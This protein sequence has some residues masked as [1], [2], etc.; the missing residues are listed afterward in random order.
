M[1]NTTSIIFGIAL[2]VTG[3]AMGQNAGI[4]TTTPNADSDLELGSS[5]KGLLLNRVAL[6]GTANAA[7]L[8]AHVAGMT[9][10]NTATAGD[11]TPGYYYNDGTVWVRVAD[12]STVTG[13]HDWYTEGGTSA[14]T[15]ITD[16]IFTEGSLRFGA[17]TNTMTGTNSI[18][19]G[20]STTVSGD[21]SG[22]IG[23][24]NNVS[25]DN[26]FSLGSGNIVGGNHALSAGSGNTVNGDR[27]ISWG[28]DNM[29]TGARSASGGND[30]T[31]SG[32]AS[33]ATGSTNTV[34]DFNSMAVG[35]GNN[36]AGNSSAA[37]GNGNTVTAGHNDA[38]AIGN[39]A[40]TLLSNQMVAE[41]SNDILLNPTNTTG[42]VGIGTTTPG[43]D[44][45][46]IAT[47]DLES[48]LDIE[49]NINARTRMSL[50]GDGADIYLVDANGTANDRVVRMEND[51][52]RLIF[53]GMDD[54]DAIDVELM[55][56]SLNT[57]NVGI[58]TTAP[59][60]HKLHIV[61]NNALIDGA[62]FSETEFR[63]S[64]QS[65]RW[66]TGTGGGT[67]TDGFYIFDYNAPITER[68]RLV[69]N[70]SGNVGIGIEAPSSK[71]DVVSN[72]GFN[73]IRSRSLG[74]TAGD[75]GMLRLMDGDD[76]SGFALFKDGTDLAT[77]TNAENGPMAFGT[78][79]S[80]RMRIDANGY[81]GV[82]TS[83]PVSTLHVVG[84]AIGV[85]SDRALGATPSTDPDANIF[86]SGRNTSKAGE[87]RVF[88]ITT[89][90]NNDAVLRSFFANIILNT[91]NVGIGTNSP[92][93]KLEV[94]GGNV[95]V[96]GGSFI[97]DG[98]TI[99]APDYVFETYFGGTSE[100]KKDYTFASLED[101]ESFVKEN[102]HLP[103]IQSAYEIQENGWDLS[104]A[105]RFNLEKVEELFLH[106]IE[107]QKT[108]DT[109]QETLREKEDQ[110]QQMEDRLSRMEKLIEQLSK[111]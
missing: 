23:I 10:Y 89:N 66:S 75:A 86:F 52:D 99:T 69:I 98:V 79:N 14:P 9:V 7:P 104:F 29:V 36:V 16:N 19:G 97:D 60:L 74:T 24:T 5:D 49:D 40:T 39:A 68:N 12:A 71:L 73:E 55:A 54:S 41:Y 21:R 38:L 37:I 32:G 84:G 45:G 78:N 48:N 101:I 91:N 13:D 2:L 1:K 90:A 63:S 30:N 31:V 26:A 11:V 3:M 42:V 70:S 18:V 50:A 20:S 27:A 61:G 77:I 72:S 82:G 83:A 25:S 6:T 107:Q 22:A 46:G 47:L 28:A 103:G 87:P 108:I 4:N 105:S 65:S 58:G 56:M 43:I 33:F 62:A 44:V 95:L 34:S 102:N 64:T 96:T 15:A 67:I 110:M 80:E 53:R 93:E 111:D 76:G 17:N 88:D 8:S 94:S 109:L 106:T 59:N 85:V 81:V 92:T 100:L 51:N 35:I 57:G